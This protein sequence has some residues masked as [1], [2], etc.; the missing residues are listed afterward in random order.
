MMMMDERENDEKNVMGCR[1]ELRMRGASPP[2]LASHSCLPQLGEA[3]GLSPKGKTPA[4]SLGKGE[5]PA[6]PSKPNPP[7]PLHGE[8]F[9]R[10]CPGRLALIP[11]GGSPSWDRMV[12]GPSLH[13]SGRSNT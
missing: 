6:W 4:L 10:V 5:A 1:E 13:S 7:P 8:A 3:L 12:G 11:P 9:T 2:T